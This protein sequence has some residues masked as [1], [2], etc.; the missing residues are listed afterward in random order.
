MGPAARPT[1]H[2]SPRSNQRCGTLLWLSLSRE[3]PPAVRNLDGGSREPSSLVASLMLASVMRTSGATGDLTVWMK[4]QEAEKRQLPLGERRESSGRESLG[5]GRNWDPWC[6][7][8][9]NG[10][11]QT[12]ELFTSFTATTSTLAHQSPTMLATITTSGN[13]GRGQ[14]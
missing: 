8:P 5:D 4:L 10:S 3:M 11:K 1:E 2:Q 14:M 7:K 9:E 13:D 6:Q 12:P